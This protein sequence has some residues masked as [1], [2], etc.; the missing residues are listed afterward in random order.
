MTEEYFHFEWAST[1]GSSF[2][3]NV[4]H[5]ETEIFVHVLESDP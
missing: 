5:V 2:P 1:K 4:K 3:Y